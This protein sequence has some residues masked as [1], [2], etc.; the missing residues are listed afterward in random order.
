MIRQKLSKKYKSFSLSL[1]NN[2]QEVKL[3]GDELWIG[4]ICLMKNKKSTTS[5]N[6]TEEVF[7]S[8]KVYFA[9]GSTM[10]SNMLYENIRAFVS[11][12]ASHSG[13][14]QYLV[15]Y[16]FDFGLGT[17]V[18]QRFAYFR[19]SA[20]AFISIYFLLFRKCFKGLQSRKQRHSVL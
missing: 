12:A 2:R 18:M 3:S 16:L 13:H 19:S 7:S 5:S 1:F 4:E 11:T 9:S 8:R 20:I 14:L 17:L 6:K 15:K 10:F